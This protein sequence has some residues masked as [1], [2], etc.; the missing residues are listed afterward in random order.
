MSFIVPNAE[1]KKKK[2]H[3]FSKHEL[4]SLYLN[5]SLQSILDNYHIV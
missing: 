3:P 2:T 4:L 5:L 1:K